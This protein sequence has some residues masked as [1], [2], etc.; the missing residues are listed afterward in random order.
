RGGVC[1][2][3]RGDRGRARRRR[4]EQCGL[5][6]RGTSGPGSDSCASEPSRERRP[7]KSRADEPRSP[8]PATRR[9]AATA[10]RSARETRHVATGNRGASSSS[11]DAFAEGTRIEMPA[12]GDEG[13]GTSATAKTP[14]NRARLTFSSR[15]R[16]DAAAD[17]H[18]LGGGSVF[19][20]RRIQTPSDATVQNTVQPEREV[21]L[22]ASSSA[23][24]ASRGGP[25]SLSRRAG[26]AGTPLRRHRKRCLRGP[27]LSSEV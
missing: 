10:K 11:S 5:V 14:A 4:S 22:G 15:G 12:S 20:R 24:R 8:R 18:S 7:R 19:V 25:K 17:I 27:P 21:V 1:K 6:A 13:D 9:R 23:R 16:L 2:G 26:G 3:R